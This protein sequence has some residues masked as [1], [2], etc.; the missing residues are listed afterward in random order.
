MKASKPLKVGVKD[1]VWGHTAAV[2]GAGAVI[3]SF[4]C[5]EKSP[6]T[7]SKILMSEFH[8]QGFSYNWVLGFFLKFSRWFSY[9][10]SVNH[11]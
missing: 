9:A 5:I 8:P 4:G 6:G 10:A 7:L 1:L 2:L 3:H 11:C